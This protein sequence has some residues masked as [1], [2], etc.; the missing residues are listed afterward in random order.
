M[1]SQ[2]WTDINWTL[3]IALVAG[4]AVLACLGDVLGSKYGKQRISIFGLRPKYTSR[5]ITAFTGIFISISVLTVLS[6]FSQN[7][8]ALIFATKYLQRQV[9]SLRMELRSSGAE[10]EKNQDELLSSLLQLSEQRALLQATAISLD[11]THIELERSRNDRDLLLGEK[12]QLETSVAS[13]R[14]ESE[15]LKRE[16]DTMRLEVIAIRANSLLAQAVVPPGT[17]KERVSAILSSLE[18][19]ARSAVLQKF[20]ETGN[21]VS[22][23]VTLTFDPTEEAAIV[24]RVSDAGVRFYLRAVA[25]ENIAIGEEV[26]IRL[27][28][29][30]SYL[31]Y[32]R[33]ETLYRKLIDPREP[34]FNA[35]E[36]LHVFLREL[37]YRT[38]RS[39]VMPDPSTN[40]VGSLEGEDFFDVV[41]KMKDSGV[42]MI[43]SAVALEDIYTEGPVGVKINLE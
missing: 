26:R 11:M 14:T 9:D 3:I 15:E 4:S 38:I 21:A 18:D 7:V 42:P 37:R 30:R 29:D 22:D 13:L 41:E 19:R 31:L 25:V 5:L 2:L 43:V 35:E 32:D 27:E 17:P 34:D 28:C 8:R 36:A 1:Q 20:F 39:G 6:F 12:N 33:G 24:L 10:L 23:D 40:S 16:L